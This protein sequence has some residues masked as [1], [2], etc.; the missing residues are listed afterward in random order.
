[1]KIKLL[2]SPALKSSLFPKSFIENGSSPKQMDDFDGFRYADGDAFPGQG[3]SL[4]GGDVGGD[5][6][7][8]SRLFD[9][10]AKEVPQPE[11][12]FLQGKIVI[13]QGPE[14]YQALNDAEENGC[15]HLRIEVGL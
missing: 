6:P 5:G 12:F 13:A 7:V 4:N 15:R 3:V 9:G 14:R 2:S 8:C 10:P 11:I 1:M